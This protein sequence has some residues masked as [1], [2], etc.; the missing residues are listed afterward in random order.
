MR[1]V[2]VILLV[3][4]SLVGYSQQRRSLYSV[5]DKATY[6]IYTMPANSF[7][8]ETDS[9]TFYRLT[10]KFTTSQNMDDVFISGNYEIIGNESFWNKDGTVMYPKS[11][12]DSIGINTQN[13]SANLDV[14]GHVHAEELT[15]SNDTAVKVGTIGTVIIDSDIE[16][17]TSGA[18]FDYIQPIYDSLDTLRTDINI[19]TT[20]IA[21]NVDSIAEHR[22]DINN[23]SLNGSV[24]AT[25][26]S[27]VDIVIGNDTIKESF[28]HMHNEYALQTQITDFAPIEDTSLFTK[29]GSRLFPKVI[30][31]T[32]NIGSSTTGTANLNIDGSGYFSDSITTPTISLTDGAVTSRFWQCTDVNGAGQWTAINTALSYSG[33]WNA[34]TNTPTLT[35]G[36]GTDGEFYRVIVGGTQTFDGSSVDFVIGDDIMYNGT[37]WEKLPSPSAVGNPLTKVDD[38]NVT[39]TLGGADSTSLVNAASI[40]VG[41]TGKL[42]NSRVDSADNWNTAYD[43][44]MKWDGGDTDLD[45]DTGRVSLGAT[46][47]G[48]NV[49]MSTD[50]GAIAFGRA[51]ADNT[52]DWLSDTLFRTAIEVDI[53]GTDNSTDVT[54]SASADSSGLSISEQEISNQSSTTST[55]GYLT[56]TDWNTFNDKVSNV[57]HTGDV[58]GYD[59]LTIGSEKVLESM[60]KSV[61]AP[62]DEY[63]LTYEATG[64][65]FAWEEGLSSYW[66]RTLGHLYPATTTDSIGIGTSSPGAILEVAGRIEISNTGNSVFIGE[67]AGLND[68]LSTNRNVFIGNGA[69][70]TNES[71]SDNIVIG[72]FSELSSVD[73]TKQIV[74]GGNITGKANAAIIGD[75]T[76]TDFY[77]GENGQA[78]VHLNGLYDTENDIGTSGQ[79]LSSTITGTNW[80]DAVNVSD[81]TY[82][83]RIGNF[84]YPKT[85]T[86]SVGIGTATPKA[87][88]D[89]AGDMKV[90]SLIGYGNY[91]A[92]IEN[93]QNSG[94]GI[95]IITDASTG[96]SPV[97]AIS[98]FNG[99]GS[100]QVGS[101]DGSGA[102]MVGRAYTSTDWL[103]VGTNWLLVNKSTGYVGINQTNPNYQLEVNGQTQT[104][105]IRLKN[106]GVYADSIL[107]TVIDS[108]SALVTSGAVID[109]VTAATP[110]SIN[111]K[112]DA[113]NIS[114]VQYIIGNDTILESFDHM[115]NEYALQTQLSEFI[116]NDTLGGFVP[117]TGAT[118]S[119]DLGNY[120]LTAREIDVSV[121]NI[122]EI[123]LGKKFMDSQDDPGDSLQVLS[124][125]GTKTKWVDAGS[126]TGYWQ[127]SGDTLSPLTSSN[128]VQLETTTDASTGIIFK[129]NVPFIHDFHHPTGG[130]AIPT[131][132]NIFIGED[133]GNF[134]MGSTATASNNSSYN[135]GIGTRILNGNT[136]GFSNVAI[137]VES[138][139]DNT[140]GFNNLSIGDRSLNN[141]T[142]GY[143]NT[144]I[145]A[146][147]LKSNIDGSS[148]TA[149]GQEAL[150]SSVSSLR[151]I[152]IGD[153]ALFSST[154]D[155]NTAIGYYAI[156]VI[157]TG[158]KNTAIGKEAGRYYGSGLYSNIAATNSTYLGY[159]TKASASGNTNETVIGANAIGN[160]SNTATILD[161]NGTD[162]WMGENGQAATIQTIAKLLPTADPPGSPSLGWIY[163]DT[164]THLYFYNG[165]SWVQLDN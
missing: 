52:F 157:T 110:D 49:F 111:F 37:I 161:N 102:L 83:S 95:K 21:I 134:T 113:T 77:L 145:G 72:N 99:S 131:G 126:G 55:N 98:I 57:T 6:F 89:V 8:Y 156:G 32:L 41:W 139:E 23:F 60:L 144:S 127:Q 132:N 58:T 45:A 108:D 33:T 136:T 106:I 79:I 13:P 150:K 117:Y 152:A 128:S 91:A 59:S 109:Y 48:E 140:T 53:A 147:S 138:L 164:D 114:Q 120:D 25:N 103:N 78:D 51:N 100:S 165:S 19:N 80:I 119:V 29:S 154:E 93:S 18:V 125:T 90:T 116:T 22:I 5:P 142:T 94:Y 84:V 16:I 97:P 153:G 4:A 73:A 66:T 43:D 146:E 9:N 88:L 1:K 137:G 35:D 92:I 121:A 7:V 76:I 2:L 67:D 31:D 34:N 148:N 163:A 81:S 122:N 135:I 27:Q 50:P 44:T 96:A 20:N 118:G 112:V 155:D 61:N 40:T 101:F 69:G 65:N 38:V 12:T 87:I 39:L 86:D 129:D 75:S 56:F 159:I 62:T 28:D 107:T 115:H 15:L 3:V 74:I 104:D 14:Q 143:N 105:T 71:G 130:G 141:N 30:T 46:T 26:I 42:A 160:G 63:Y 11:S 82:W 123:W 124:S 149:I 47:I 70:S 158:S 151:N 24:D 17:P 162:V 85:I 133:A 64:G 36:I 10:V 68:D 54:L